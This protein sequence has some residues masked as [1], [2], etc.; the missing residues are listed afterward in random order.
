MAVSF[1]FLLYSLIFGLSCLSPCQVLA[2][3]E[4]KREEKETYAIKLIIFVLSQKHKVA[5]TNRDV[6]AYHQALRKTSRAVRYFPSIRAVVNQMV[7]NMQRRA[8]LS[9]SSTDTALS[10]DGSGMLCF[11]CKLN[12]E[13]QMPVPACVV[14]EN[15]HTS[16]ME[17][18][19]FKSPS[20]WK[21]QF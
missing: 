6:F 19:W 7:R 13:F 21:S 3:L 11:I 1:S 2:P 16:S 20:L 10:G 17:V 12:P 14:L 8:V 15:N 4:T 5:K 18:F 9:T